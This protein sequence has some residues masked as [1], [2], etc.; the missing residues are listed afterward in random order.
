MVAASA[1]AALGTAIVR[2]VGSPETPA[3]HADPKRMI[4]RKPIKVC[5]T[6]DTEFSIGSNFEY[7]ALTRSASPWYRAPSAEN[8]PQGCG[9]RVI[10]RSQCPAISRPSLAEIPRFAYLQSFSA[11]A[12][13]LCFWMMERC[14]GS[15]IKDEDRGAM[16]AIKRT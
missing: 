15:L 1:C 11:K 5:I 6:I 8:A 16:I 7:S 14:R 10:S 3:N 2:P 12:R 4:T 13:L 9:G